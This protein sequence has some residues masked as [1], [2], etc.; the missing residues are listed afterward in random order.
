M[1]LPQIKTMIPSG[2]MDDNGYT[3]ARL[4]LSP[5]DW[6]AFF[7]NRAN[8]RHGFVELPITNHAYNFELQ[9]EILYL[10]GRRS[11]P[12]QTYFQFN[13][14]C[15]PPKKVYLFQSAT[16]AL[17]YFQINPRASTDST[18]LV[19]GKNPPETILQHIRERFHFAKI[20]L[21]YPNSLTGR[22]SEIRIA[23]IISGKQVRMMIMSNN[24][25][26][27]CNGRSVILPLDAVSLSRV[28]KLTGLYS[29]IRTLKPPKDYQSFFDLI[30]SLR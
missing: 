22:I 16:D 1:K 27:D 2:V 15:L 7:G 3:I 28:S 25:L 18:F 10:D 5:V 20:V 8:F 13:R 21:A 6:Y 4:G 29:R 19:L 12:S 30:R 9:P 11:V 23:G 26:C 17:G 14:A 24:L